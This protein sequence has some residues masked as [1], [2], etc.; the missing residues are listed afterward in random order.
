MLMQRPASRAI[1]FRRQHLH[2]AGE[3]Q[4][5]RSAS[6]EQ[7]GD[8]CF[9]VAACVGPDRQIVKW[10]AM[11]FG[12]A[13]AGLVVRHDAA[14]LDRQASGR[15]AVKQVVQAMAPLRDRDHHL[16]RCAAVR[17]CP[18][19]AEPSRD[20]REVAAECRDIAREA[21]PGRGE[22]DA[23]EEAAALDVGILLAVENEAV[24]FCQEAARRR[25]D[26]HPVLGREGQDVARGGRGR[27][28]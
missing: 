19:E 6:F 2:V 7:G 4:Q 26:P 28:A 3:D 8:L 21:S 1:N 27:H 14:D 18:V 5:F 11:P 25:Y 12:E 16:H 9:L 15:P 20:G 13:T 23:H 22:G 24:A 10:E 17:D